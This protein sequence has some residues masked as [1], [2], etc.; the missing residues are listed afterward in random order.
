MTSRLAN[1]HVLVED[2]HIDGCGHS[3]ADGHLSHPL[4]TLV[5]HDIDVGPRTDDFGFAAAS[6]TGTS[7]V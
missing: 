3:R 7:P 1:V 2:S 6:R 4:K 5:D